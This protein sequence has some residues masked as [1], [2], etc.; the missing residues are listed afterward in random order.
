MSPDP[1][2]KM[3]PFSNCQVWL[4]P[5]TFPSRTPSFVEI[6]GMAGI[7]ISNVNEERRLLQ[8]SIMVFHFLFYVF[9]VGLMISPSES[10]FYLVSICL[11]KT[12]SVTCIAFI[13][14]TDSP[15]PSVH[16]TLF[17][18]AWGNKNQIPQTGRRK[19]WM[20]AF[21]A[22]KVKWNPWQSHK[23]HVNASQMI[24]FV[25][26]W[27]PSPLETWKRALTLQMITARYNYHCMQCP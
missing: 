24:H 1:T 11:L 20:G 8:L 27:I 17:L 21:V 15:N 5:W 13:L 9:T 19:S 25:P 14:P 23:C 2:W 16:V 3:L 7:T 10:N 12:V 22:G 6:E 4:W 26:V 18:P